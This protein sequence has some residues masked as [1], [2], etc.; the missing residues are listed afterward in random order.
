MVIRLIQLVIVL[1]P[2]GI[3]VWLARIEL[4]PSGVFEL[5]HTVGDSSPYIDALSPQDR[6]RD[7][8]TIIDDPVFFFLHPHRHFDKV[9][10]DIWFKNETVPIVEFGGLV[11]T[12]PDA[13]DLQPFHHRLID[14]LGWSSVSAQGLT[15]Y[16]KTKRYD[17]L[18]AFYAQPPARGA[19]AV[20]K[21]EYRAPFRLADYAPSHQSKTLEVSLRGTHEFKTYI[22]NETLDFRFEYMDMNRDDGADPITVTLFNEQGQPVAD[23]RGQDDRRT[24]GDSIPSGMN[25]L[26]LTV[27]GLAEGVYK[28]VMNAPRDIFFRKMHTPQ[29]KII[30]LHS[31][32]LGDEIAYRAEPHATRLWTSSPLL[33]VQTRHATGVQ[34][35]RV[36]EKSLAIAE[37]YAWYT[38][39]T[40]NGLIAVDVPKNDL[41]IFFDGPLA[42]STEAYFQP[43]PIALRPYVNVEEQGI[44]YILTSY[45]PP[46]AQNGW[47]VQ[48]IEID[49][50]PLVFDKKSWK[51]TFST[52]EIRVRGGEVEIGK[53]N[54]IWTRKPFAWEDLFD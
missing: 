16:Q 33:R 51:F 54:T 53:I 44:E 24:Q 49:A 6:V 40:G 26:S 7:E 12:K 27:P 47:L 48:T 22:K 35:L 4:V 30:F 39:E 31:V 23:A 14:Q 20:Y 18:E 37:P 41:E 15:L 5:Q 2:F 45:V 17:S 28:V 25:N 46:R 29:Q 32:F 11:K 43:D 1:I 38:I 36:G 50:L 52:P 8:T 21:A 19:V 3:F 10:F 9:A 34:Q 42:F 13:Y